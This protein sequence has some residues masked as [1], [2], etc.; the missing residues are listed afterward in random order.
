MNADDVNS[1]NII[2]LLKYVS[3]MVPKEFK[4]TDLK[5]NEPIKNLDPSEQSL[6]DA[7]LSIYLGGFVQMSPSKSKN[8]LNKFQTKIENTNKFKKININKKDDGKKSQTF[9]EINFML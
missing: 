2:T 8:I 7:N 4:V 5:I 3:N 9:Y 6:A 1:T